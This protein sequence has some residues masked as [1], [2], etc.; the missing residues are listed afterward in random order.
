VEKTLA[1]IRNTIQFVADHWK[2]IQD[3]MTI[4]A[5]AWGGAKVYDFAKGI[6]DMLQQVGLM[7]VQAGVVNVTG[8]LPGGKAVGEAEK[9]AP[10][11]GEAGAGGALAAVGAAAAPALAVAGGAVLGVNLIYA[12][13]PKIPE[14]AKYDPEVLAEKRRI[15]AEAQSRMDVMEAE[16][17]AGM[18]GTE[19][20]YKAALA[21]LTQART[22]LAAEMKKAQAAQAAL[23]PGAAPTVLPPP[24]PMAPVPKAPPPTL[25]PVPMAPPPMAALPD[26]SG[27]TAAISN[28]ITSISDALAAAPGKATE[29]SGHLD[30]VAS[31]F[32]AMPGKASSISSSLDSLVAAINSAAASA[33]ASIHS[34]AASAAASMTV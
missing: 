1:S 34:A 27:K 2:A 9:L 29:A 4:A 20:D 19:S 28:S 10:A 11:A 3:G 33:A 18:G 16:R 13:L 8:G 5:A 25:P 23:P 31:T 30:S 17:K 22:Q 21:A 15:A 6:R 24:I 32:S 7:N 12:G 14:A 26:L